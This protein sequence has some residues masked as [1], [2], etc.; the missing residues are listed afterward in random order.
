V[1]FRCLCSADIISEGEFS[2]RNLESTGNR[3]KG[4]IYPLRRILSE[5]SRGVHDERADDD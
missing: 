1:F 2:E 5:K 3:D 4:Q